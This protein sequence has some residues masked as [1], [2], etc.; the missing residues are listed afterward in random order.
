MKSVKKKLIT[1]SLLTGGTALTIHLLNKVI[2]ASGTIKNILNSDEEN[3][4]KWRYGNVYYTKQG[5]GSPIL[6]IHDLTPS[7][8]AYEWTKL[9]SQLSDFHTVYTLDLLGCGRSDKPSITYAN[10]LYVQLITDFTKQ[11][12]KEPVDIIATGLSSSFV[13]NAC[14]LHSEY[15]KKIML[16]NPEDLAVLN[17]VPTKRSKFVKSLLDLPLIGT[18]LYY[19]IT[20][21]SNID[22]QFTEKWLYNPFHL[23]DLDSSAYYEGAHRGKGNGKYLLSSIAGNYAYINITHS[24]KSINNSIFILGGSD[25][26]GIQET[27]AMYT[28]LNTSVESVLLPKSKHLPQLE[29]PNEVIKQIKILL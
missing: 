13:I 29:V 18:M 27:I 5:A 1:L 23:S 6:L 17:H 28:A 21:K 22:L 4:F 26:E 3:Y 25:E 7:S 10:Y 12:I 15:F 16:I 19:V 24:L 2:A 20:A 11:I 8:S 9:V 14:N